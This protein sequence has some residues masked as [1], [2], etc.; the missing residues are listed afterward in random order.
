MY[1]R[2]SIRLKEKF[3]NQNLPIPRVSQ[4]VLYLSIIDPAS[5]LSTMPITSSLLS[6]TSDTKSSGSSN[7]PSF[8][9]KEIFGHIPV[10]ETYL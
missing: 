2:H 7:A 5:Q 8:V 10:D 3:L 4:V 6:N 9:F 1:I